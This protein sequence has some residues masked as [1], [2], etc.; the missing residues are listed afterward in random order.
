MS[1]KL[2]QVLDTIS[3]NPKAVT[4]I[5]DNSALVTIPSGLN[6]PSGYP[7]IMSMFTNA[8]TAFSDF[9][10][11]TSGGVAAKAVPKLPNTSESISTNESTFLIIK[12]LL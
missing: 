12:F 11:T 4:N 6:V 5:L 3:S 2:F 9:S 8:F 7:L 1:V 10:P